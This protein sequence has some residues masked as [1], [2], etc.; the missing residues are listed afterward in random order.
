MLPWKKGNAFVALT[1]CNLCCNFPNLL[2]NDYLCIA[3][4][5]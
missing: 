4:Y 1:K 5:I 2:N 3:N